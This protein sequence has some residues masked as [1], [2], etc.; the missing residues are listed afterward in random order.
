MKTTLLIAVS[1]MILM[2]GCARFEV[3]SQNRAQ[4]QE[5]AHRVLAEQLLDLMQVRQSVCDMIQMCIR[6]QTYSIQVSTN[7]LSWDKM[8]E[9]YIAVYAN[10]FTD[11]ELKNCIAFYRSSAG[12]ALIAKQPEVTKQFSAVNQKILKRMFLLPTHDG[13][14]SK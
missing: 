2:V 9:D 4:D 7:E 13:G 10:T 3:P 12:Q 14:R 5:R 8:K 6:Q 1:T 11:D